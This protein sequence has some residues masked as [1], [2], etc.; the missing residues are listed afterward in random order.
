MRLWPVLAGLVFAGAAFAQ[1]QP[2]IYPPG[3][4][5]RPL[6]PQPATP[7][8]QQQ[9]A[10]QQ[11]QQT[12]QQAPAQQAPT[13]PPVEYGGLTLN[14]A[15]L[16]QV[17]DMLARQLHINYILDKRVQG[18]V[19][20]N[21]YGEVKNIDTRSLLEAIL[22]INGFGMVKQ[23]DIYRIVPLADISHMP[24]PPE[25]VTNPKDIPD[26]D[27]TMLNLVFLKYATA[28]ELAKVLEPFIGENAKMYW[29]A[30]ANLLFILDSHRNMRRTME[31]ISLFD[32]DT[33]AAQRVRLFEVKHGRPSDL[34]KDLENIVKSIS[35][36]DKNSPIKFLPVD[37][38][39]TIIAIA[40]NPGAFAEVEKWLNKIDIPI[41]ITAGAVDNYVYRVKYGNAMML[42][43]GI[44][45][46]YGGGGMGGG[47][48]GSP[49]GGGG[50][51]GMMGCMGM[52]GAGVGVPGM[53]GMQAG[54]GGMNGMAGGMYGGGM[55]GGMYGAGMYGGGM[56]GGGYAPTAPMYTPP[57]A[58]AAAGAPTAGAAGTAVTAQD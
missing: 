13:S 21:T 15:S 45:M 24:L 10:G 55:A 34:V 11:P 49:Y 57:M 20:L 38:I 8:P 5:P 23:G 4:A 12:P 56:Y 14:N 7:A 33:L 26:D 16:A 54:M 29:Y 42:A 31:L 28:D 35:L 51:M 19:I 25:Q 52:F 22:R 47:G 3:L 36:N 39:N 32:N 44:T 58:Q 27:R 17:I 2:I 46:L 53:G 43:C 9:P 48:Y 41:K 40:P 1:Q 50:G 30:P 37:R 18:G 6:P